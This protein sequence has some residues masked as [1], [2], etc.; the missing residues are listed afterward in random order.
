MSIPTS[1][2]HAADG[3]P[4]SGAPP[5]PAAAPSPVDA[6]AEAAVRRCPG[7]ARTGRTP[8]GSRDH[9]HLLT[10]SGVLVIGA[11]VQALSGM[12]FSLIA[13]NG[14]PKTNF[15]NASALFTSVLFVTYL[16]GLGLPVSLARYSADR[17]DDSHVIF[18]WALA[19]HG[20]RA[21]VVGVGALPR[22]RRPEG[23][24]RAVVLERVSAA[25]A[26]HG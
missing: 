16:A 6:P 15:G 11:G 7:C 10:G 9:R 20:R 3:D 21:A 14:D 22:R 18:S 1:P 19:G 25:R 5:S 8:P 17:S 13:A 23:R 24:R 4:P 12:L 26:V 2:P